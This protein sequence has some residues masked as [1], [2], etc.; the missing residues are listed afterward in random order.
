MKQPT[1]DNPNKMHFESAYKLFNQQTHIITHGNVCANTQLS[2]YI[3]PYMEIECNHNTNFKPGE[4]MDFDLK[5]VFGE[6]KHGYY[7]ELSVYMRDLI[8]DRNRKESLILYKFFVHSRTKG[9]G[10]QRKNIG[11]VLTDCNYNLLT[12]HLPHWYGDS[13]YLK[14]YDA[15]MR[16]IPYVANVSGRPEWD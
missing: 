2:C 14:R 5:C 10:V 12:Y 9:S 1:W 7:N 15:I 13:T 4:L 3:R 8:E 6:Y 16:A 11:Y